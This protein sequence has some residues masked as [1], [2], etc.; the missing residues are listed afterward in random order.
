MIIQEILPNGLVKTYSDAGNYIVQKETGIKYSEAVD[1]PNKYTYI[2]S[3]ELVEV[4][5][6]E[7]IEIEKVEE[8]YVE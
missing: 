1:V 2:E 5:E 4:D 3:E 7:L 6:E 8:Y